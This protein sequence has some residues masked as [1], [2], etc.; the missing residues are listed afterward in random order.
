MNDLNIYQIYYDEATRARV[1]PLF[2]PLDNTE[3]DRPDWREYWPIRNYMVA[4][5]LDDDAYYGFLS[6]KF[7]AKTG[8]TGADVV[9]FIGD[10]G[11]D[12]YVFSQ[13][14]ERSALF[15]N[16][17]EQGES[18]HPGLLDVMQQFVDQIGLVVDLRM[19]VGDNSNAVFSNY[20]VAKGRFWKRWLAVAERLFVLCEAGEEPLAARLNA[21]T[22]YAGQPDPVHMKVFIMERI[23]SFVIMYNGFS[24][25]AY[26]S[27]EMSRSSP[28]ELWIEYE[29]RIA[30]ALKMAFLQ[31][32]DHGY[33][34][35]YD[36]Y[37]NTVI[38]TL[39]PKG[40]LAAPNGNA[41]APKKAARQSAK[42]G[43]RR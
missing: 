17:F 14:V 7:Q 20:F 11:A 6:P 9:G 36:R 32:G 34:V 13:F 23:A 24:T 22:T 41:A 28:P 18:G 31:S 40:G 43:R 15:L 1:D 8:L 21:L 29:M 4:N 39:P 37:R 19:L 33:V 27:F 25:A 2:I 42:A 16:V 38:G 12:V 35:A 3:N 5:V 30:N 26:N 10:G